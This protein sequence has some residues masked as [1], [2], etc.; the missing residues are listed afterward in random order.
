MFPGQGAQFINMGRG[1]YESETVFRQAID[2]CADLLTPYLDA[3]IRDII[4]PETVNPDA[5][6]RLKNTR[7]TQPALFV[8]EYAL[9]Q[10][11]ISWGIEPTVFCGHSIGEFVAAHLSGVFSLA[12]ALMLIA[13]RGHMVSELPRGSMLSVRLP[14]DAVLPLLPNTLAMAAINSHNL[15]VVA[16]PD[17]AIADFA[18]LLDER[19]IP[20]QLLQTSHAFH[21]AMMDPIV[22]AFEMIIAGVLLSRPQKPVVSTVSGTWLTDA[23]ATDPQYW[24]HHLRS[25][26]RFADALDTLFALG[27]P[28]LLEVGPGH[29]TTTLA[30]QQAPA[31]SIP[32]QPGIPNLPVQDDI[33]VWIAGTL[34]QL[35]QAGLNPNWAAFYAGQRRSRVNLPTYAFARKS[36]WL[37]PVPVVPQPVM[38]QPVSVSQ[39]VSDSSVTPYTPDVLALNTPTLMRKDTLISQINQLLEDA[40]GIDMAGVAPDTSFLEIGLDSLL[41]TQVAITLKKEFGLPITFRQLTSDYTS[42]GLLADYLDAQLPPDVQQPA[43]VVTPIYHQPVPVMSMGATTA[44]PVL[45]LIAQQ[46][47]L[48]AKQIELLQTGQS[49]TPLVTSPTHK[50]PCIG[51]RQR[52]FA[53]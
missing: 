1:L 47:Q 24:A 37:D 10:L 46:V 34:G 20:N 13:T 44:N 42:P 14:A 43:P 19:E 39:P 32:I 23:Q 3:D 31:K 4:Y 48:L 12:D 30:R 5:E 22:G 11:W 21:S 40:S 16:G 15:C 51:Q 36:Y 9:A 18:R 49:G 7:Y 52:C 2:T 25:T 45:D 41:L 6:Q 53:T 35:F 38:I 29:V 8:T 28:L 26:V 17:E 33:H 50:R 27:N